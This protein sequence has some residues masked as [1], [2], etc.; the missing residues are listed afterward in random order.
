MA[1]VL[2]LFVGVLA[3]SPTPVSAAGSTVA[4]ED[5]TLVRVKTW[6]PVSGIQDISNNATAGTFTLW[7]D[8]AGPTGP[9]AHDAPADGTQESVRISNDATGGTFTLSDGVDT[10]L[11][12]AFNADA[13]TI[14]TRL[15]T[16]IGAITA[17]TAG[18]SGTAGDPWVMRYDIPFKIPFA[19]LIA[20][21][22]SLLGNTT[23]TIDVQGQRGVKSE[24]EKFPNILN[25]SVS[26]PTT[27]SW[28]VTFVDRSAPAMTYADNLTG[29]NTTV[30]VANR[31]MS[32]PIDPAGIAWM[33]GIDQLLVADSEIN[34]EELFF[35]RVNVWE[36]NRD[37]EFPQPTYVGISPDTTVIPNL[38]PTGLAYDPTTGYAYFTN[39]NL[40]KV[41]V[42]DINGHYDHDSGD[43]VVVPLGFSVS[44]FPDMD[45]EDI[46]IDPAGGRLFLAGGSGDRTKVDSP[47]GTRPRNIYTTNLDGTGM[48]YFDASKFDAS[49]LPV[50]TVAEAAFVITDIEGIAYRASSGTLLITDASNEALYELT[51][52]GY[53]LREIDVY[54]AIGCVAG[55]PCGAV[56]ADVA[57][58]PR[59][60]GSAGTSMYVVDRAKDP[61]E[62]S[63]DKPPIDG[64]LY[65]LTA[66]FANLAPFV[67]AGPSQMTDS[68]T[69]SLD[70]TAFD[71]GQPLGGLTTTWSK[72]S[73]SGPVSF[74]A[75]N[76]VD[77]TVTFAGGGEF[78]LQLSATDGV[79]PPSVDTVTITVDQP[80]PES[81]KD[82]T[83]RATTTARPTS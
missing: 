15:E 56:L 21:D 22:T 30:T 62:D 65:E 6:F 35:D 1:T 9:L 18:G 38:E 63:S 48:T 54:S 34:E 53:L 47:K 82:A 73:G 46:A 41:T 52:D 60:D 37:G 40:R 69:V 14:E 23:I 51:T 72:V 33:S 20:D 39:D 59:S 77:S 7:F 8:G 12:I 71:D 81:R 64:K 55:N 16:D 19:D 76:A 67:D 75:A 50:A 13:A 28:R 78:V 25:V 57:L 43:D 36:M 66:P 4:A 11:P 58:A 10:T 27:Q 74:S 45:L 31:G 29:G 68:L 61:G 70:G 32:V 83:R 24:L 79:N 26:K 44:S 3:S 80:S 2:I 17:I 42:I 49:G 5:G